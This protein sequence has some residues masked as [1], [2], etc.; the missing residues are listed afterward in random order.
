VKSRDVVDVQLRHLIT[1]RGDV[2]FVGG[3]VRFHGLAE[4]H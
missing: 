4:P 1:E 2:E 3:E